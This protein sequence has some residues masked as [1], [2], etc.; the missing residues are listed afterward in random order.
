MRLPKLQ[1]S[2]RAAPAPRRAIVDL[3]LQCSP[4]AALQDEFLLG[5]LQQAFGGSKPFLHLFKRLSHR[6]G[7]SVR[8]IGGGLCRKNQGL[9]LAA[10]DS[11]PFVGQRLRR[12]P[13]PGNY[14]ASDIA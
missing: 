14:F 5:S 4:L 11:Q 9:G 8:S 10:S 3:T 7:L 13:Q 1:C 12:L 6:F 2:N